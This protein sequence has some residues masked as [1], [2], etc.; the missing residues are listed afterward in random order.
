LTNAKSLYSNN[1]SYIDATF[2][3][4]GT[5]EPS[6]TFVGNAVVGAASTSSLGAKSISVLPLTDGMTWYA[7]VLSDTKTCYYIR[8]TVDPRS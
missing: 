4:L 3:A 7:A 2:T 8:D 6:L 5:S 1:G